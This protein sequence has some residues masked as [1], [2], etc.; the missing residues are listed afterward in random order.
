MNDDM[1]QWLPVAE[2][3]QNI[4]LSGLLTFRT[5]IDAEIALRQNAFENAVHMRQESFYDGDGQ[6]NT[7]NS[8]ICSENGDYNTYTKEKKG[9]GSSKKTPKQ[10]THLEAVK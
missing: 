4:S 10:K 8:L 7:E 5:I 2:H 9:S 3:L 6:Q 1:Q